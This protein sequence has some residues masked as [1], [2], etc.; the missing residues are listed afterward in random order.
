MKQAKHL[1]EEQS[2]GYRLRTLAGAKLLDV[3]RHIAQCDACRTRL[4]REF[5]AIAALRDLRG[6]LSEHLDYAA[7]AACAEGILSTES[8]Q[9]LTE[10][11]LCRAEVADLE[12]FRDQL[13]TTPRSGKVIAMPGRR[14]SWRLPA[15]V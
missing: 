8:E 14:K 9:H 7:V 5:G 1:T 6:R 3:D 13:S 4:S 12:Q 15:Y 10:C 2:S 11:E